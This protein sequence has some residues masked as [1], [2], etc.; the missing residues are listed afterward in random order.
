M[1][2]ASMIADIASRQ[3][4]VGTSGQDSDSR[5]PMNPFES[6]RAKILALPTIEKPSRCPTELAAERKAAAEH[7][8]MEAF[9]RV[10]A[11]AG[12]HYAEAAVANWRAETAR[13]QQVRAAV[14]EYCRS[15]GD[16]VKASEGVLLYGPVGT[17]KDHLAMGIAKAACLAGLGV[18]WMRGQEWFGSLRD[19][20]DSDKSERDIFR[21]LACNVL[22][23]S[24]PLPP[25]GPLTQYQA[26]MLY[27]LVEDRY[28]KGGVIVATVNVASD[29]EADSRMGAQTWDRLKDRAWQIRCEWR[30]FRKPS[31][32]V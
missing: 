23:L 24:D 16:R 7:R 10:Q 20:M 3:Q 1:D 30:S 26:S 12:G 13:Q 4:T 29:D 21:S 28:S 11:E 22:I 19:A 17:G 18:R 15:I 6:L 9:R 5:G 14:I 8:A 2:E 25:M 31:R 32:I 27:R